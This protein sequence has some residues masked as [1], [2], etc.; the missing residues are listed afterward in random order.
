MNGAAQNQGS[1]SI[2][3]YG[4]IDL[5]VQIGTGST[6]GTVNSYELSEGDTSFTIGGN[7]NLQGLDL[8]PAEANDLVVKFTYKD[9]TLQTSSLALVGAAETIIP[10]IKVYYDY[11]PAS[12]YTRPVLRNGTTAS[13]DFDGTDPV[14]FTLENNLSTTAYFN[15][16]GVNSKDIFNSA[17]ITNLISCSVV[18]ES[19]HAG[20]IINSLSTGSF[21]FTPT[22]TGG[23]NKEDIKFIASNPLVYGL[24]DTTSSGSVYG[25][26]FEIVT[27][28][29]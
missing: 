11:T 18:T 6:F 20:F 13:E 5:D 23:V 1:G 2:P 21:T 24:E 12:S 16:E 3:T 27:G 14:T 4:T 9:T 7:G 15:I 29:K 17:S 26:S 10:S 8:T 28:K 19:I 22:T 25:V